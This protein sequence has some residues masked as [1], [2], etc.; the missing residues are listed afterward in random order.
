MHDGL[1]HGFRLQHVG[2]QVAMRQHGALGH[3]GGA[4]GE[5]DRRHVLAVGAG[6]HRPTIGACALECGQGRSTPAKA[7]TDTGYR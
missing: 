4:A 6:Q 2:R 5:Q 1:R 3:A 7:A